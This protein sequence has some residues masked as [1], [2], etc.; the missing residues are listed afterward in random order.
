MA[1]PQRLTLRRTR[2]G[3]LLLLMDNYLVNRGPGRVQCRGHRTSEYK[4]DAVQIVDRTGGRSPIPV[5][6]GAKLVWHYVDSYRG[7]YW[8][9]S[10]AARFELYKLND[11]GHRGRLYRVG[12][13]QDYCLRDLFRFG[14][15]PSVPR[16][17]S[18]GACSQDFK[19]SRD[20]LG[21]SV[22]WADGY[23]YSYPQNWIDVTGRR[24]CFVVIHRADPLNHVL[25]TSEA[26]NTSHRVVRLP[27]R[28][29]NQHCPRYR[30]PETDA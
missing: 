19:A 27:Y 17:P 25:E 9:F 12:P 8:K 5:I 23:P 21:I 29:G 30:G 20:T 4:M 10:N 11:D 16:G 18:F 22:G 14:V 6:T 7:S 2:G 1:P 28:S 15:G 26:D 24:G 3:R 13:K